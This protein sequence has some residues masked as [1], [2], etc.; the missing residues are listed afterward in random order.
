[1]S[2]PFQKYRPYAT[3][4]LP[5]RAWPDVVLSRDGGRGAVRELADLVRI[6][7]ETLA[8]NPLRESLWEKLML[9]LYRSGRQAEALAQY[10]RC[11]DLLLAL[12]FEAH[13]PSY[14]EIAA[15]V[16]KPKAVRAVGTANGQNRVD[17][18][19]LSPTQ[20]IAESC[21]SLDAFEDHGQLRAWG[22][23]GPG[24]NRI[25]DA[26]AAGDVPPPLRGVC[27]Q[28]PPPPPFQPPPPPD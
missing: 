9:A 26:I 20:Q 22:M 7:T 13:E 23:Y 19:S 8:N 10:R 1:M 27:P 15:A 16:G 28:G 6:C 14:A 4:E 17:I 18:T 2:M 21:G 11:R 12:Y 24:S 25:T 3:V 5:D